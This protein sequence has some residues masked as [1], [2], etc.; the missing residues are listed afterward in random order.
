MTALRGLADDAKDLINLKISKVGGLTR[1]KLMRDIAVASGTP[2]IVEDTWSGDIVTAAIAH[3][4][5]STPAEFCFAATDFDSYVTREIA[6]GAP[7]RVDGFMTAPDAQGL[8]VVPLVE[9]FGEP[10][11]TIGSDAMRSTRSIHII[12]CHAERNAPVYAWCPSHR[13]V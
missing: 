11:L 8:G 7:K 3:L 5:A 10:V 6:R 1:A 9:S 13:R 12:G 4:A 2:M